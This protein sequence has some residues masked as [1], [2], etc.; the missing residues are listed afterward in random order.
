[1]KYSRHN[2]EITVD[3]EVSPSKQIFLLDC[4]ISQVYYH[5]Y[6]AIYCIV[7]F[8]KNVDF[9]ALNSKQLKSEF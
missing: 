7:I 6:I 5:M 4:N 9:M 8:E 2:F 3:P 1:M